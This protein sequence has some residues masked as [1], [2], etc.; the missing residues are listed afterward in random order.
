[1]Y[2]EIKILSKLLVK[3]GFIL[4]ALAHTNY[5]PEHSYFQYTNINKPDLDNQDELMKLW[6]VIEKQ[7]FW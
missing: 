7:R 4:S 3:R 2:K 5:F 1:M 6:P